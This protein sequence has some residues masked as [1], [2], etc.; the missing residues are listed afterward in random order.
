M[1]KCK[2][3]GTQISNKAE[4][5]PQCGAPTKRLGVLKGT[6]LVLGS[7]VLL[8]MCASAMDDD[9]SKA[10]SNPIEQVLDAE[11]NRQMAKLHNQVADDQVAQYEM[12]KKS[13]DKMQICVHAGLVEASYVQ[14]K[15]EPNF[16]KWNAIKK[17]DCADAGMPE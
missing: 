16:Q 13:G 12:I 8:G 7:L 5:C 14:A 9:D 6:V 4:K 10:S 3:C 11:T 15:D 17:K 2:E 1:I